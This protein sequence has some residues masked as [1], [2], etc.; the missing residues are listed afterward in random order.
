MTSFLKTSFLLAAVAASLASPLAASDWRADIDMSRADLSEMK[1]VLMNEGKEA[2]RMVYAW[3]KEGDTYVINDLTEMKPN[4]FETAVGVIDAKTFQPLSMDIDF[5]IGAAKMIVDLDWDGDHVTGTRT[6]S[7]PEQVDKVTKSDAKVTAPLRLSIFGL[8]SAL[9]LREGYEVS[10]PW[11]NVM[12]G[13]QED[14][15]L[16]TVGSEIIETP[17]GTFDTFKVEIKG[18]TPEN[19]VYVTKSLPHKTV[20]I[21]V[22]GQPMMFLRTN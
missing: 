12:G 3:R 20:R 17:A 9:P 16:V 15:R 5:A 19:I 4:I 11:Y 7:R 14:I 2:G 22:V 13:V 18:A 6:I 10:L 8:I 1:L 21:D